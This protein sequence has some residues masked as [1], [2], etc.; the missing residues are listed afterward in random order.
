M[1]SKGIKKR[2]LKNKCSLCLDFSF[3]QIL[4][5]LIFF[6]KSNVLFIN[7]YF[8]K[9]LW[10]LEDYNDFRITTSAALSNKSN[11]IGSVLFGGETSE[12][13]LVSGN[14]FSGVSQVHEQVFLRPDHTAVLH[15][16]AVREV[17]P[18]TSL[19]AEQT[20]E[21]RGSSVLA[22]TRHI[23]ACGAQLVEDS[24]ASFGIT[25][26]DSDVWFLQLL[27]LLST[28]FT[29]EIFINLWK[30]PHLNNEEY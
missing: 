13:H 24:L 15:G 28:H 10:F 5:E 29:Y 21:S 17:S 6:T 12:G 26:R 23:V 16:L 8:W 18:F 25:F 7:N 9:K 4:K 19:G 22:V 27:L 3:D 11:N 20:T 1:S 30:K 14:V 2:Q